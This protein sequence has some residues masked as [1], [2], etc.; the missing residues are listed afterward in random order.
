MMSERLKRG[1]KVVWLGVYCSMMMGDEPLDRV[2]RLWL[3]ASFIWGER[4]KG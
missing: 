2:V 1:F 4:K 3:F